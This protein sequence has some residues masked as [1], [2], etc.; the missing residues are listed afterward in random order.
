WLVVAGKLLTGWVVIDLD[1]TIIESSSKKQGAAG[2]FKM[3]FGFQCAMRR[4]GISP[5][6]PGGTWKE[7]PGPD[8]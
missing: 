2:T 7:V 1:A 5:A 3:T 6:Q 4:F 8:G